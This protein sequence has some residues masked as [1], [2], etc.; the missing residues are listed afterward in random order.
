MHLTI[1]AL[2]LVCSCAGAQVTGHVGPPVAPIG[3]PFTISLSNDTNGIYWVGCTFF[4]VRDAA[5]VPVLEVGCSA[6]VNPMP[7]GATV[8]TYWP[9][10][11]TSGAQVPPGT[12]LVDFWVGSVIQTQSVTIGGV[13]AAISILGAP[14]VGTTRNIRVCSPQDGGK[15][16]AMAA[17]LTTPGIATCAGIVP[18]AMDWLFFLSLDPS[19]P[20]F[21]NFTGTLANDG[22]S[23]V[24]ALALPNI[25]ALVGQS[26]VLAFVV[27]DFS[28]ACPVLRISAPLTVITE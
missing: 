6:N 18:L 13:D 26:F 5:G 23:E 2:V 27:L 3:C 25:P 20:Y 10:T 22:S 19:N 8:T 9:Q 15:A 12:Y 28:Q 14:H 16:F 1:F 4:G 24:S 17:A 21:L 11:N 7:P